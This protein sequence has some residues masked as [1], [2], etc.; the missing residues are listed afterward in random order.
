M[1]VWVLIA[2]FICSFAFVNTRLGDTTKIVS[3]AGS[4]ILTALMLLL[5]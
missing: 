3:V 2:S 1:I 4:I 5:G